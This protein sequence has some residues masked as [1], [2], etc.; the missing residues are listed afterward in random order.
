MK[1]KSLLILLSFILVLSLIVTGCGNKS[2]DTSVEDEVQEDMEEVIEEPKELANLKVGYIYTNHQTPLMLAASKAEELKDEGIY[3]KEVIEKQK[4]VLME[5]DK[6]IANIELV[7]NKS[8]SETMTMIAQNHIDLAIASNTA[9]ITARDQGN[10]VRILC[11]VHTEGIGLVVGK[12]SEINDWDEFSAKAKSSDQPIKVGYHS[13]TSAP[14]ILFEAAL[15][16][17][18]LT[19]TKDPEDMD[20]DILLMDLKGTSNFI[21]AMTSKQVEAWVGPSPYPELASTENVG[22]IILDMKHLPP[23]GKWYDFPCCV[24]GTT[25]GV[26]AEYP[27]EIEKFVELLTVSAKYCDDHKDEAAEVTSEF[28]GVALEA[29]KMSTIKY[30]TDPSET[31]VNNM[32]VTYETLKNTDSLSQDLVD[33]GYEDAKEQIFDFRFIKNILK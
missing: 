20:A 7:V 19:Y 26:I 8:G 2:V 5:N 30:T 12:D 14:L 29:A 4:Y 15:G 22:K 10:P 13:P 33:K 1:K 31:W 32:G 18:G 24:L 17:A 25:E 11:P 21:P 9:F 6:A 23:E 16:E 28:T 27:E 3:L